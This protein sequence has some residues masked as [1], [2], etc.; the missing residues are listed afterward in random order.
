MCTNRNIYPY[1]LSKY[2][3]VRYNAD[4][5]IPVIPKS[6]SGDISQLETNGNCINIH[7]RENC[8]GQFIRLQTI[9]VLTYVDDIAAHRSE[10][11]ILVA[12]ENM[13]I[14]S[15]GPCFEKCDPQNWNED[16]YPN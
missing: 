10:D 4:R 9:P 6:E 7:S 1:F 15:I 13:I 8:T 2:L 3:A 11:D 12:N 5:C 16:R 14:G